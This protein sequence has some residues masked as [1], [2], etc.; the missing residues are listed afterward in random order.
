MEQAA[1]A[2]PAELIAE[3][4]KL[5]DVE[6]EEMKKWDAE[7]VARQKEFEQKLLT[8]EGQAAN[9]QEAAEVFGKHANANGLLTLA[10][11]Q[12]FASEH[13]EIRSKRNEPDTPQSPEKNEQWYNVTNKVNPGT[14]GVSLT[15]IAIVLNCSY[16]Y[17]KVQMPQ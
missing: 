14:D 15:E 12:S 3:I 9:M 5:T 7:T 17:L 8:P 16:N 4:N 1:A 10:E 6:I 2:L 13:A 11:F